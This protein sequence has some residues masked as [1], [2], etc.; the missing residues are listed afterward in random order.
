MLLFDDCE[1]YINKNTFPIAPE[2]EQ[3][4]LNRIR[5]EISTL[6]RSKQV[7]EER[8][9]DIKECVDSILEAREAAL[10]LPETLT[11]LQ[12]ADHEISGLKENVESSCRVIEDVKK[13]AEEVSIAIPS[14]R[15]EVASL[16]ERAEEALRMSTSAGLAQAFARNASTLKKSSRCWVTGFVFAL[17]AMV[18]V[19][20]WRASSIFEMLMTAELDASLVWANILMS[21]VLF[22][23]HTWLAWVCAKRIAHLFRLI[24]DYEFKAAISMSYEGYSREAAKYDDG[25]LAERVL[26]SALTRFD[27][28]P[29]RFVETKDEGH[30][31]LGMIER[32]WSLKWRQSLEKKSPVKEV[33]AKD[34]EE[35]S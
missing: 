16:L 22:A 10:K 1:R 26:K 25:D 35:K 29:L 33:Q 34:D 24:E 32:I 18:S 27:E 8:L 12:N 14:A 11:S 9:K 19:G 31:F 20:S 2:Q 23:A 17:L 13:L 4:R 6:E 15:N 30:P 3:Q 7:Q 28:P 21:T 5:K